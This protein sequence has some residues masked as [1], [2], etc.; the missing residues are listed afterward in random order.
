MQLVEPAYRT[1]PRWS[2]TL[3]GA[4]ADIATLANYGPDPEQRI[5]LDMLFAEDQAGQPSMFEFAVVC[6]RQNLKTGLFKQASL[7][8]LFL[9]DQR[10]VTWS[11]HEFST[12]KEAFRDMVNLIDG[13]RYLSKRVRKVYYGAG[14]ESIELLN[15]HRM[16]FKA[17]TSTGGRGLSAPKVVLD[18][19]FALRPD[20]LAA[21]M[22]TMSAQPNPQICYG[23]SAG[24]ATSDVLRGIRNRGRAGSSPRLGY[25]EWCAAA[26]GCAEDP[27]THEVGVEG[28]A[29]DDPEKWRLAN[30]LM[31]RTRPNGTGMTVEYIEAE[32]HAMAAAPE[33]F[34]RERLG[35][36]DEPGAADSFGAGRWEACAAPELQGVDLAAVGIAVSLN[37]SHAALVG[38]GTDGE[39]AMVKPLQHGPGMKWVVPRVAVLAEQHPDVPFV[40]DSRGPGALLIPELTALLG[41]RLVAASTSDVLD[42]CA[43]I[44]QEVQERTF[45]H[46]NY[47]E[48]DAAV[49]AAVKR[50]VQ[51]RWA[52]GRRRSNSDISTLEA[53]TL[54]LWGMEGFEPPAT[55]AYEDHDL[56]VV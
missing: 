9:T 50:D 34:A 31:G 11:A 53:A 45:R 25:L 46:A 10:L 1:A 48:L 3:G 49:A 44:F 23:S 14:D 28:C 35:W 19:A 36:W 21:L 33:E 17:R 12:A 4:V 16:I 18:E 15:G 7:G 32:R 5:G 55:S 22:P 40:I 30:P 43:G 24:M 37:L 38:A 39:F 13:C 47:P 51:D 8:W 26:G 27:C 56:V 2:R 29:L 42:A 20:H 52:W 54:G 6:A 41:D